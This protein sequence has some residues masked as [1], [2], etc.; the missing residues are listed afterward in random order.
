MNHQTL[1]FL[2]HVVPIHSV[3][4]LILTQYAHASLTTLACLQAAVLN[5]SLALSVRR[6]KL[7]FVKNA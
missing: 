7:V 4:K 3:E 1:A 2:L 5:A 6:T